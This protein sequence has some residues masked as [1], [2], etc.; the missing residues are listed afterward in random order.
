MSDT[1]LRRLAWVVFGLSL[2]GL[3]VGVWLD[4]QSEG[5]DPLFSVIVFTFPTVGFIVANRRPRTT[6]AW[7]MLALGI[8]F[9]LPLESYGN[10]AVENGLPGGTQAMALGG[11]MWV[12]FIGISGYLLLLFP[13][14]HLPSPP[15]AMVLVDVRCRPGAPLPPD[16]AD[17]RPVREQRPSR[18]RE[19]VRHLDTELARGGIYVLVL[20]APL[21]VFGGAVA[22]IRRLRRATDPVER[23]Q[24][25]WLAW[26]AAWIASLYVLA[27]IPQVVF[28]GGESE[29][30]GNL[31]GPSP[32]PASR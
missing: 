31:L 26:A 11:P 23:Q 32:R 30:W 20:F 18:R 16:R 4:S 15:V 21:L 29:T 9:A 8:G 19:P 24:L 12:P 25:R 13:D 6:L 22:V 1:A 2:A 3:V 17:P 14:G 5:G 7:L 10:Y 28:G 27:F